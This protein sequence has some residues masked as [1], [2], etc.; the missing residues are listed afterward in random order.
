MNIQS[1]IEQLLAE[2]YEADPSLREREAVLRPLLHELVASK[3]DIALDPAFR[4][5]VHERLLQ[6]S[7]QAAHSGLRW[8]SFIHMPMNKYIYGLGG[9]VIALVLAVPILTSLTR[10]TAELAFAPSVQKSSS[11]RAFGS[12]QGVTGGAGYAGGRGGGG[13]GGGYAPASVARPESGGGGGGVTMPAP[14]YVLPRFT[15]SGEI[16][17]EDKEVTVLRR[18]KGS[19]SQGA[20]SRLVGS[21][22]LGSMMNLKSFPG[23]SLWSVSLSQDREYGYS[24]FVDFAEGAVSVTQNW[25][26]WPNPYN[27]CTKTNTPECYEGL[28]IRKEQLPSDEEVLAAANAFLSEHGISHDGYGAPEVMKDWAI[29]YERA[30]STERA[31]WYFPE[32]V[33]A[34]YPMVIDGL[35]VY[36]EGG[37]K[38]GIMLSYDVRSKRITSVSGLTTRRYESSSYAAQTDVAALRSA[39]ARGTWRD[40]GQIDPVARIADVA[41]EAPERAWMRTFVPDTYG[42]GSELLVPALVFSVK[43]VPSSVSVWQQAI[44]LPL[45]RELYTLQNGAMPLGTAQ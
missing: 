20:L 9:A 38:A 44:V 3:P 42:A 45:A 28:R 8:S 17:L 23:A 30:S 25:L 41:V 6:H 12:L 43:A 34:V 21:F 11:D 37:Q 36:E 33:M 19:L 27:A 14:E 29:A 16:S 39:L 35:P 26:K 31:Q 32:Q 24:I 2:L 4:R 7:R 15:Y 10:P 22:D 13:G 40:Y 1:N 18:E 5:L